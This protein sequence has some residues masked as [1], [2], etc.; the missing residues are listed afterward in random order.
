MCE[1]K[2]KISEFN[3][4]KEKLKSLQNEGKDPFQITNFKLS[5]K[6]KEILEN[7]EEKEGKDVSL[8]GRIMSKRVMGNICFAHIKD[9]CGTIQC[10]IKK[11]CMEEKNFKEFKKLDVGDIIGVYGEVCKTKTGEISI[12]TSK[13]TLLTKALRPLPEKFHGLQ[14]T[15][16]RYR[17][18]YVDLIVNENV[19]ETFLM[20]SKILLEIRKFLAGEGFVEVETPILNSKASGACAKPFK[21]HHNALNLDMVLRIALELHL[22]RLI[23]GGFNKVYEIGKVFRNEGIDTNHNPEF[24]LLELYEAYTD[25]YGMMEITE[26]LIKTVARNVLE[27]EE[28]NYKNITIPLN[29]PFSKITMTEAVLKYSGVD[30]SKIESLEEAKGVALKKGVEFEKHHKV[31]DILNLFFEKFVEENLI[32]PTFITDYPVE[33][34]PLAKRCAKNNKLTERFELFIAGR[35]FANAFSELNDPIDQRERFKEQLKLKQQG[36]E[37]IC[38]IDEDFLNALEYGMPPTGG[39]GIGV[40][41]LVMLISNSE[42]IRDVIL[43]PTMKDKD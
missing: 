26:N 33:I 31:G 35:E 6:T 36:E 23:V 37:E 25:I 12:K 10:Y 21:T 9:F 14:N 34:S 22:K 39:M 20:R 16:L 30:F 8:A 2:E 11:D 3:T 41:R 29:E 15:D 40:D 18:R 7:F 5:C 42:S 38:D 4:R 19:K 27:K 24:T 1:D 13:I 43:F 28:I 32:K 17:Q